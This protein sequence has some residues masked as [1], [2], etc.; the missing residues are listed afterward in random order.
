MRRLNRCGRKGHLKVV[1]PNIHKRFGGIE[2]E[3]AQCA[4]GIVGQQ[5]RHGAVKAQAAADGVGKGVQVVEAVRLAIPAGDERRRG[6]S[7]SR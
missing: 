5:Q 4:L 2:P 6:G 1:V 3:D 7:D